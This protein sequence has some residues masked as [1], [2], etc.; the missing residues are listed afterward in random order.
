VRLLLRLLAVVLRA[1]RTARRLGPRLD[2]GDVSRIPMRVLPNDLDLIGH[3]N[4]GVY[5][6][7]LDLGRMDLMVRSGMWS[8]LQRAGVHP[9]VASETITFRRSLDPWQRYE[10]E[11]RYAGAD[12]RS[13]V[14]IEQ[15][16][17]VRGEIH[18]QA[19]I[20]ARFLRRGGGGGGVGGGALTTAELVDVLG[21]PLPEREL[22]EWVARWAE[23]V[24]LPAARASARSD[25]A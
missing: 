22:P 21:R 24:R 12:E 10:V 8:A 17:T 23:A 13:G 7:V 5:L 25:W 3:M 4:N 6:T 16:F 1:R 9:V 19:M 20:R 11:T 2:P 15:R 14:Y 18:A